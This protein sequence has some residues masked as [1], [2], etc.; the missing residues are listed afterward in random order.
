M[1]NDGNT[2]SANFESAVETHMIRIC[3]QFN[4]RTSRGLSVSLSCA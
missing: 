3:R 4:A 1:F 2:I